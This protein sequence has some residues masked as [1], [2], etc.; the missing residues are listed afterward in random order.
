MTDWTV[1]TQGK[2]VPCSE[3]IDRGYETNPLSL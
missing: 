2:Q 1:V 3:G